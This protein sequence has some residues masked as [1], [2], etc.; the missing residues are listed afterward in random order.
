MLASLLNNESANTISWVVEM[1]LA[2]FIT[3]KATNKTKG[4]YCRIVHSPAFQCRQLRI[5]LWTYFAIDLIIII[6]RLTREYWKPNLIQTE[7]DKEQ[8]VPSQPSVTFPPR[9][10]SERC[11]DP[12][13]KVL[14]TYST[15]LRRERISEER[16][17]QQTNK[18]PMTRNQIRSSSRLTLTSRS[19]AVPMS[20]P[21][22][23]RRPC[24]LQSLLLFTYEF[25]EFHRPTL[26]YWRS[27][28]LD[29]LMG[30]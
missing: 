9:L 6:I 7:S 5:P 28:H 3:Q 10:Y 30:R 25:Y 18:H 12:M 17:D 13:K 26:V 14:P 24:L 15:Q 23:R 29:E 2:L 27:R 22:S 11:T 1:L 20:D 8:A 21:W 19:A 4:Q 16:Y